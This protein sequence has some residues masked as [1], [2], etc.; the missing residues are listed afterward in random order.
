MS[1]DVGL[2]PVK[3]GDSGTPAATDSDSATTTPTGDLAVCVNEFMPNNEAA[4]ADAAG[5]YPDWVEIHNPGDEPVYL[6]DWSLT[7]DPA[8][9]RKHVLPQGTAIEAEGYLLLYADGDTDLGDDHLVFSLP[10]EGGSLSLFAPDG[11]GNRI[12]FGESPAD[13]SVARAT[14]CCSGPGCL[15]YVWQGTP[16]EANAPKVTVP[17]EVL[18]IGSSWSY[19]DQGAAPASGWNTSAVDVSGWPRGPAPLGYGDGHIV[20][21]IGYGVDANNKYITTWFRTSVEL[22]DDSNIEGLRFQL[23]RDDGAVVYVNGLEV[24]RSNMPEGDVAPETLALSST[25]DADE[26][27]YFEID[28]L[29]AG[30]FAGTNIIAVELH[31]ASLTSSDLGFDLGLSVLREVEQ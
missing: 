23:L 15:G 9:P 29:E 4:F 31:Q 17:E 19:W 20:T 21:T 27:A 28:A 2:S 8:N 12:D 30:L 16:G 6:Q 11:R 26:T 14:D 10:A 3:L 22:A 1:C 5:G 25:G 13:F 18:P 24:L 7:D